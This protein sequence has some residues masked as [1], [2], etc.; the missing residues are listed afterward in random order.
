MS[1]QHNQNIPNGSEQL[2]TSRR[3]RAPMSV[4]EIGNPPIGQGIEL[5]PW[6]E[7]DDVPIGEAE[8]ARAKEIVAIKLGS[9]ASNGEHSQGGSVSAITDAEATQIAQAVKNVVRAIEAQGH[10]VGYQRVYS[11]LYRRYRISSYKNLPRPKFNEAL[12]W[13]RAWYLE[14]QQSEAS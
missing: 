13:L 5:I 11:E 4:E 6:C 10:S 14:L 1:I 3:S 7:D 8:I 12:S 9:Q 2:H